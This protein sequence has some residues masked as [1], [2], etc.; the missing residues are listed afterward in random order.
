MVLGTVD[1][2]SV[3]TMSETFTINVAGSIADTSGTYTIGVRNT[4][5]CKL[6]QTVVIQVDESPTASISTSWCS[7][8]VLL[9]RNRSN[10][11]CR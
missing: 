8:G 11:S 7:I 6:E 1:G 9:R 10:T 4:T 5:G 3:T 2:G